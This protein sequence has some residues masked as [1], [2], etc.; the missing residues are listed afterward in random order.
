MRCWRR[1]RLAEKVGQLQ[2][3][4]MRMAAGPAAF[5]C[6]ELLE[7]SDAE[8]DGASR[9]SGVGVLRAG[10]ELF[11]SKG[12]HRKSVSAVGLS[13]QARLFSVGDAL[14]LFEGSEVS[15]LSLS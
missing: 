15:R 14:G 2:T 6:Q 9:P 12:E 13:E 10:D 5:E 8:L 3:V 4:R 1:A 7:V 11:I